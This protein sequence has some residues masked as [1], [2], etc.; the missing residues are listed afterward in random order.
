MDFIELAAFTIHDVKNRLAHLAH[1]AD[2]KGD[3]ETLHGTLEAAATLT[4]LLA[5]YKAE[6][7]KLGV[8][9]EA[10]TPADLVE[11]LA[12]EISKQSTLTISTDLSQ[13]PTL[14]FYDESLIRMVL[15]D[16]LYNALRHAR[17]E[18]R[19]AASLCDGWL[20]FS[21]HDDGPGYPPALLAQPTAMHPLSREGTGLGLH[22]ASQIAALHSNAGLH[23]RLVLNNERGAL[24][25][26]L[27]PA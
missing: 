11:E 5:F 15:L 2:E 22:L 1:R 16:A 13:A 20:E 6:K 23:G 27:L 4:R 9:I 12:I 3:R 17:Q 21:V 24:F 14:W 10:R 26:L 7:G 19:L 25:R 8:E 18:V